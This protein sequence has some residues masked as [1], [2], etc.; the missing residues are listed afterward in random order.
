MSHVTLQ[1]RHSKR[2]GKNLPRMKNNIFTILW[3]R[4][5]YIFNIILFILNVSLKKEETQI[6]KINNLVI[7]LIANENN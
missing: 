3:N 4:E 2:K 6:F 7:N 1:Y 5:S